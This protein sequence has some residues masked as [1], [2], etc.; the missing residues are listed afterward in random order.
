MWWGHHH[1]YNTGKGS[2]ISIYWCYVI[3]EATQL[4]TVLRNYCLELFYQASKYLAT[5]ISVKN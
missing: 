1:K 3:T 5:K 2:Q 4:L